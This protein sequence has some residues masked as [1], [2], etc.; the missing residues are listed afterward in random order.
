[1]T[2]ERRH[3][4]RGEDARH[5][6]QEHATTPGSPQ[7]AAKDDDR[8]HGAQRELQPDGLMHE[9]QRRDNDAVGRAPCQRGRPGARERQRHGEYRQRGRTEQV[10][11]G[12]VCGEQD[13][14]RQQ[15]NQYR[16][17]QPALGPAPSEQHDTHDQR[18]G[19][20][21]DRRRQ[22]AQSE[23][24]RE[25]MSGNE[26]DQF[27]GQPTTDEPEGVVDGVVGH[28]VDVERNHIDREAQHG[29][30]PDRNRDGDADIQQRARAL[31]RFETQVRQW[32]SP[33][34]QW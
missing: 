28:P 9:C 27:T 31:I 22:P 23:R 24:G 7:R 21:I 16:D 8:Q 19:T 18:K 26:P 25:V 12:R 30:R 14:E 17:H 20:Q 34:E 6:S 13:S 15:W 3:D 1:V 33:N 5:D 29:R 11:P 4:N 10:R 2:A 32:M